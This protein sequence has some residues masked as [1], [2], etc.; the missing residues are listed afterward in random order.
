ML[1]IDPVVQVNVSVNMTTQVQSVF[2]VGA[3]LGPSNVLN[4]QGTPERYKECSGL[5]EV[6]EAGFAVNTPEYIAAQKYFGVSPAPA[7]VVI[8][9]YE[10][11]PVYP[12]YNPESTYAVGD[13]V[14]YNG[15]NYS[16]TTAIEEAETWNP[17]HWSL[18]EP[19]TETPATAL[20]DAVSKGAEFYGVYYIPDAN[21]TAAKIKEN[22]AALDGYLLSLDNGVQFYGTTGTVSEIIASDS[23]LSIMNTSATKRALQVTCTSAINDAAG[24]MG[25]AMGMARTHPNSAVAL[26]YKT[27]ASVT[28]NN[29]TQS[30]VDSIKALNGNVYVTRTKGRATIENGAT[31]SGM[32][33]D[34]VLYLD[35]IKADLKSA[36][37][38]LIADSDVKLPQND[39]TTALFKNVIARILEEYYA[40]GVLATFKWR[41]LPIANVNT[42]DVVEHGYYLYADTYDNQTDADR[43]AHKAMPMT[44]LLCLSGSVESVVLNLYVQR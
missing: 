32:R 41:G 20:M 7:K 18:I 44:I 1:T 11:D 16:C 38:S 19:T 14:S 36:C 9:H 12:A 8:V 6:L 40:R 26:S 23:L 35:M 30:E 31:A 5:A 29:L 28:A 21:A 17:E 39:T 13:A 4:A 10:V 2:D 27:A 15:S 34:E 25:L 33:Y 24:I 3:I 43:A 42:G 37:F 22:V